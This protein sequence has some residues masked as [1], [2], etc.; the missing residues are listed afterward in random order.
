[1]FIQ[2]S[3]FLFE[4]LDFLKSWLS[5]QVLPREQTLFLFVRLTWLAFLPAL[6]PVVVPV[7]SHRSGHSW[8]QTKTFNLQN[9]VDPPPLDCTGFDFLSYWD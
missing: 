2:C 1:M 6:F 7:S 9:S 3:D 5:T 4:C 8:M